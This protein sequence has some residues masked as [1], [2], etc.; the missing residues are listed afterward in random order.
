MKI[1]KTRKSILADLMRPV[2]IMV[3]FAII[4]NPGTNNLKEVI[5]LI[6]LCLP[7]VEILLLLGRLFFPIFIIKDGA[8]HYQGY[9]RA[10]KVE[11]LFAY[12]S[13]QLQKIEAFG[14]NGHVSFSR[15]TVSDEDLEQLKTLGLSL[16]EKP[17]RKL[18]SKVHQD[19]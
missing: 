17:Q 9:L 8:V 6:L 11:I 5:G 13:F 16:A 1:F 14:K 18:A 4:L 3:Y 15:I 19:A 2:A 12:S 10:F 7:G